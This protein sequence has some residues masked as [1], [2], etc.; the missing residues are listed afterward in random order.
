MREIRE[1]DSKGKSIKSP[2]EEK[3]KGN[4]TKEK[5]KNP[6]IIYLNLRQ[7]YIHTGDALA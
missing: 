6:R 4:G 2:K 5:T 1:R 3:V 7:L